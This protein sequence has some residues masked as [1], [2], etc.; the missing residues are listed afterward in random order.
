[1]AFDSLS[2]SSTTIAICFVTLPACCPVSSSASV[3]LLTTSPPSVTAEIELLINF[4][5][6][7]AASSDLE[8]KLLTSS[9]TTAKPLPAEP[10]LA[11]STAA[12]RA[13]ILI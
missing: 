6:A 7:L 3:T 10:A 1:M 13:K 12:F 5:V 9:A 11:A 4:L 2:T 8:A